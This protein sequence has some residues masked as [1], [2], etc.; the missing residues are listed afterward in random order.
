MG[1]MTGERAATRTGDAGEEAALIEAARAGSQAAFARLYERH[2]DATWGFL[3]QLGCDRGVAEDA[4]QEAFLR[5]WRHLSRFERG[6]AFR[7]WLLTLARHAAIDLERAR[8]KEARTVA[9]LAAGPRPTGPAVEGEAAREESR[10]RAR[11]ALA[12]LPL[13]TRALLVQRHG[14]GLRLEEMAASWDVTERTV[15][16]RLRA[17]AERLALALGAVREGGS[18]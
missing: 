3:L 13:E 16:N 10:R 5:A 9:R 7:P 12:A 11:A 18:P 4:L 17:A 2:K 6:R 8:G 14:M 1:V 15:R